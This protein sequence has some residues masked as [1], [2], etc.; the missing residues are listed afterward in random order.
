M[1]GPLGR[2]RPGG[3]GTSGI[4]GDHTSVGRPVLDSPSDYLLAAVLVLVTVV[5]IGVWSTG[6]TAALLTGQGW[7]PVP[8]T[9]GLGIATRLPHHLSDPANAWPAAARPLLPGPAGMGVAAVVNLLALTSL[10]VL[11]ARRRGRGRRRRGFASPA[12]I[13]AALSPAAARAT[14]TRIRPG[15]DTAPARPGLRATATRRLARTNRVKVEDVAV[16]AGRTTPA[17]TAR[18]HR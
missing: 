9:D 2:T 15:L 13:H 10:V 5:T 11:G 16:T 18:P 1:N 12:Q 4:G 8:V 14:A 7:P 3:P 6:Q 17:C